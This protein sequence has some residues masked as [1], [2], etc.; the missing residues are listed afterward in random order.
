MGENG[1]VFPRLRV[2]H[3]TTPI[4]MQLLSFAAFLRA[5]KGVFAWLLSV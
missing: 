1:G 5:Y 4:N 3:H 2:P